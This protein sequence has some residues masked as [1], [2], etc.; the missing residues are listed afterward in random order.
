[1]KCNLKGPL[2]GPFLIRLGLRYRDHLTLLQ[3]KQPYHNQAFLL[4]KQLRALWQRLSKFREW[5]TLSQ[6]AS[7]CTLQAQ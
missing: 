6:L 1:M 7:A 4:K 5:L 2:E 3:P